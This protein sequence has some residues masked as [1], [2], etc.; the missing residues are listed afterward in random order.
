M[1]VGVHNRV[2]SFR[3]RCQERK[4]RDL[5]TP[6]PMQ[7]TTITRRTVPQYKMWYQMMRAGF[8]GLPCV[9]EQDFSDGLTIRIYYVCSTEHVG[10]RDSK[11]GCAIF[12]ARMG[13]PRDEAVVGA[14]MEEWSKR[15]VTVARTRTTRCP[16]D[17]AR[18][19]PSSPEPGQ[20][21]DDP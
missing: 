6:I 7:R 15:H 20:T 19:L 10:V 1:A 21:P 5:L 4:G 11:G 2:L 13:R 8:A 12:P 3:R 14:V 18:P 17:Q 16:P 9:Y